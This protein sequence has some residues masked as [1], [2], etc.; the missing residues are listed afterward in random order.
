VFIDGINRLPF[1]RREDLKGDKRVFGASDMIDDF[2]AAAISL[3]TYLSLLFIAN[4][5]QGNSSEYK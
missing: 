1:K 3:Q 2:H 4:D 5:V